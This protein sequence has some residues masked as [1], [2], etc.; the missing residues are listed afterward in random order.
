M[1]VQP[2]SID[3]V[4]LIRP[5]IFEDERGYVFEAFQ[6]Q[7]YQNL[8]QIDLHFVQDNCVR[9]ANN[10]LRGLHFQTHQPQGKLIRVSEGAIFD[11][12]VDIRPDSNTFGQWFGTILSA[13]N[14]LQMWIPPG[15]A[16]GF[17][18]LSPTALC[19]Y[20]LTDY[21]QPDFE[22]CLIWNDPTLEIEWPTNEPLLSSKDRLGKTLNE[23]ADN[24]AK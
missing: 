17:L 1:E 2:T 11:V 6:Q 21:Y 12:A 14:Q 24:P 3:D 20:K 19:E 9:S 13:Q 15:L 18:T 23:L 4:K 7:R 16:H 5:R 10:V 8:L 22:Q